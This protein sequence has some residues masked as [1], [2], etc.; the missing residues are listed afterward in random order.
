M[1]YEPKSLKPAHVHAVRMHVEGQT[2]VEIAA[3]LD[4]SPAQIA[5]IL[6]SPQAQSL[7]AAMLEETVDTMGQVRSILQAHAPLLVEE[8]I[9]EA[10]ASPDARIRHYAKVAALG[11]AGHVKSQNVVIDGRTA[12]KEYEGKSEDEIRRMIYDNHAPANV[13]SSDRGP[14]GKP[15][16]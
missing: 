12:H 7:I 4:Y 8:L 10:V 14:D 9:K 11:M 13:P 3:Q 16:Q 1:A 6:S 15:L 5:N 2:N